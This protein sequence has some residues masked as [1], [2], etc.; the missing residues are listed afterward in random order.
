MSVLSEYI[1]YNYRDAGKE[2]DLFEELGH[3]KKYVELQKL[4]YG[5]EAFAFEVIEDLPEGEIRI[6]SLILQTL[7]ENCVVHAV[8]LDRPVEISV[9]ITSEEYEDGKYLYLCVSDTGNGFSKEILEAI[10]KDLPIIYNGRKHVGLQ[11][12][13]RRLQLLYGERASMVLQNMDENY[14]AVVEIRIPQ[15]EWKGAEI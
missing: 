14:G 13:R 8:S 6:P 12:I 7:V 4:R 2:R 15:E 11:N 1:R 9:Y 10:E 3:V 5:E